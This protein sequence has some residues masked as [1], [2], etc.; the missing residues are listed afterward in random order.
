[1]GGLTF[2]EDGRASK[3]FML[4]EA[5]CDPLEIEVKVGRS[6]RTEK[7]DLSCDPVAPQPADAKGKPEPPGRARR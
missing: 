6:R 2:G 4:D 7:L 1:M 5:A 3:A